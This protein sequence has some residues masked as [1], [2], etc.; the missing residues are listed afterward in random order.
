MNNTDRIRREKSDTLAR[1][2]QAGRHA[3]YE[4]DLEY[5]P[6]HYRV[7]AGT[8]AVQ[9][10][11]QLV[12]QPRQRAGADRRIAGVPGAEPDDR[13]CHRYGGGRQRPDGPRAGRRAAG[14]RRQGGQQRRV[15][16]GGGLRDLRPAGSDLLRPV[17]P[18]SDAGGEH[19]PDGQ[20]LSA[21]RHHR[22]AGYVLP[23]HVRAALAGHRAVYPQHVHP[24]A[25]RYHQHHSRPH[26]HLRTENGRGR[27]RRRHHHRPVL[28]LRAGY[29]LQPQK[30][31]GHHPVP[32]GLPPQLAAHR[33][34]LRHRP[35]QR[36]HD[37][38]RLGS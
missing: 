36:H 28:R 37:R 10:R 35:A 15:S 12:R 7:H 31:H 20:R 13:P 34:D 11:G 19:H 16:G 26:L 2:K 17:F 18:L 5:V 23:D 9:H 22:L 32:A 33:R 29:L 38:H 1:G 25:G 6:A 8:G 3:H 4:A 30:E 14:A 21:D 24:G 27:R